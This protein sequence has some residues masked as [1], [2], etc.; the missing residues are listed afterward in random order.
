MPAGRADDHSKSGAERAIVSRCF[1]CDRDPDLGVPAAIEL[2]SLAAQPDGVFEHG[3][4]AFDLA[5]FLVATEHVGDFGARHAPG[6]VLGGG[7]DLVGRWVAEAVAED[8]AGW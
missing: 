5:A 3:E 1:C 7:P 4:R 6:A 8:P 2:T